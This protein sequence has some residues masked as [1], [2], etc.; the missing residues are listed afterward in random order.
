M[1]E[2]LCELE[3]HSVKLSLEGIR[4]KARGRL[5]DEIR[6]TITAKKNELVRYLQERKIC[7]LLH[8]YFLGQF[9]PTVR[10]RLESIFADDPPDAWERL[11]LA[12]D[13][14]EVTGDQLEALAE[15]TTQRERQLN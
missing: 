5:T 2:I 8:R 14:L 11:L 13:H 4:I 7:E 12:C 10:A 6:Q 9:K 15:L 1:N 3:R